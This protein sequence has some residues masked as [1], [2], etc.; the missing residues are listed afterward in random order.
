LL[1]QQLDHYFNVQ[2]TNKEQTEMKRSLKTMR[3]GGLVKYSGI[4]GTPSVIQP[5][6]PRKLGQLDV[7]MG[8][9]NPMLDHGPNMVPT[10]GGYDSSG[11]NYT[12]M[13]RLPG[14]VDGPS[15]LTSKNPPNTDSFLSKN[16]GAIGQI[17]TAIGTNIA[18]N[19]NLN[20]VKAPRSIRPVSTVSKVMSPEK[21]NLS[22][23]IDAINRGTMGDYE[24]INRSFS[25]SAT[26]RA[27]KNKARLNQM[28]NVGQVYQNQENVNTQIE[29]QYR[30]ALSEAG[31]KDT[32]AN[33]EIDKYNLEN[34]YNYDLWR[35]GAKGK[36]I[37]DMGNTAGQVFG[38]MTNYQNQMEQAKVL[39]NSRE[40]SVNTNTLIGTEGEESFYKNLPPAEKVKHNRQRADLGYPPLTYAYGG[41]IRSLKK[42]PEG[43]TVGNQ[44]R[45][46]LQ[47]VVNQPTVDNAALMDAEYSKALELG[48]NKYT[49]SV[50]GLDYKVL[51]KAEKRLLAANMWKEIHGSAPTKKQEEATIKALGDKPTKSKNAKTVKD[52]FDEKFKKSNLSPETYQKPLSENS[53]SSNWGDFAKRQGAQLIDAVGSLGFSAVG[54]PLYHNFGVDLTDYGIPHTKL[55]KESVDAKVSNP[56]EYADAASNAMVGIMG[57]KALGMATPKIVGALTPKTAPKY[58][59]NEFRDAELAAIKSKTGKGSYKGRQTDSNKK[60]LKQWET[61]GR[62]PKLDYETT[63]EYK[64]KLTKNILS[65]ED[66]QLSRD[67]LNYKLDKSEVPSFVEL[68]LAEMRKDLIKAKNTGN[69]KEHS[70]ILNEMRK[71]TSSLHGK[72]SLKKK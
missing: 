51:P 68:K 46:S 62:G 13:G 3:K 6:E 18:Q 45:Q 2:E 69:A 48:Q 42:F 5:I 36:S 50:T 12:N 47:Q 22:A 8:I 35:T 66:E 4:K 39:A 31:M 67:L 20:R 14:S 61:E 59:T 30:N 15:S 32:L 40:R 37:A 33:T 52:L 72:K 19:M 26:A 34:K 58:I 65:Q 54:N 28:A 38:N 41:T 63:P 7:N 10:T 17:G 57:G 9:D 1:N 27:F 16:M 29:N 44:Y 43:G 21:I 60:S 25:N 55:D 71:Y 56:N 64:S 49:S 23:N 11:F 24:D 53:E 70:K